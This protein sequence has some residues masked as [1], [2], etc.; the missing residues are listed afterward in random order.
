MQ[1]ELL[2]VLIVCPKNIKSFMISVHKLNTVANVHNKIIHN[3]FML[4]IIMTHVFEFVKESATFP[5]G[6]I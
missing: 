2:D 3:Y 4:K 5:Y 1:T 6:F